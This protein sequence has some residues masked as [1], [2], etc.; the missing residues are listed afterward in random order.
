MAAFL[1]TEIDEMFVMCIIGEA[2]EDGG[3]SLD[4]GEF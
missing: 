4:F 1:G 3:G 2:D